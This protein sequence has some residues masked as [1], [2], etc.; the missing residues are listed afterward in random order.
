MPQ[1]NPQ[2]RWA[3]VSP[4]APEVAT[5]FGLFPRRK[6][7]RLRGDPGPRLAEA[8]PEAWWEANRPASFSEVQWDPRHSWEGVLRGRGELHTLLAEGSGHGNFLTYH[9]RFRHEPGPNWDC[10]CGEPREVGHTISCEL[11]RT[12]APWRE[13]G[14]SWWARGY[15]AVIRA[16][17]EGALRGLGATR[18]MQ[19]TANGVEVKT[20][21]GT[22]PGDSDSEEEDLPVAPPGRLT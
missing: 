12:P 6:L 15:H 20:A 16:R 19:V 10:V 14:N 4:H 21:Q 7:N 11:R 13:G 2:A 22:G 18:V 1:E 9:E 17:V 5:L 3:P 8:D